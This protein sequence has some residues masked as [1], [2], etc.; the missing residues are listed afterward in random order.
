MFTDRQVNAIL[1]L[2]L[3]QLVALERE[4]IKNDYDG[5]IE[6]IKDLM[7]ILAKEARVLGIIKDELLAVKEK[8]GNPR[9]CEILPDEGEIAIEDLAGDADLSK[10]IL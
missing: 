1:E 5:V 3:Y 8:F 10:Y 2:R 7:D 4:K 9:K 6:E